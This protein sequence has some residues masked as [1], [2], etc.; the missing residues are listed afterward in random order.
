MSCSEPELTEKILL[1]V[2]NPFLFALIELPTHSALLPALAV[3][4]LFALAGFGLRGVTRSGALAGFALAFALYACA[5]PRAFAVLVVLFVVTLLATRLGRQRKLAL[6]TAERSGGRS[7]SQVLANVGVAS[8]FAAGYGHL[9]KPSLLAA[10]AASLAEAA[11]D[12]VSSECGQ[13]FGTSARLLSNGA[14]VAPGTNGGVSWAGTACGTLAAL[15]MSLMAV[16]AGLVA[17]SDL[18]LVALAAVCGMFLDSLLGAVLER[19]G[20]LGNNSVNF[21]GT[22]FAAVLALWLARA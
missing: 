19:P 18:W 4:S 10:C 5:G 13:A 16:W 3:T 2:H 7:A 20:R 14:Q 12:T 11:A 1:N 15:G 21:L 22:L 9:G 17:A 8:L 6:G